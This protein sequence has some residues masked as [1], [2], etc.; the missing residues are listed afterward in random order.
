MAGATGYTGRNVVSSAATEGVHTVAHVRPDSA[1]LPRWRDHFAAEG[2]VVDD[3]PWT[4]EGMV[5]AMRAH[6]PDVVFSL[7]GTTAR[8]ARGGGGSYEDVDYGLT[9]MLLRAM[10]EVRPDGCFVYLSAAGADGR[11]LNAYMRARVRVESEIR[12]LGVPHLIARPGFITGDDR[13]ERRPAERIG[14]TV[15]DGVLSGLA[16]VGI[17]GPRARWHSITGPQLGR[18]LVAL[19]LGGRRGVVGVPELRVAGESES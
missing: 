15:L 11:A 7:L 13:D 8:R 10:A 9:A 3:S 2:A 6:R 1:S 14:A 19:A 12:S 4:P 18:A 17:R 5:D 16:L